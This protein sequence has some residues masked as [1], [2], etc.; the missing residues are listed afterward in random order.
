VS[1]SFLSPR[2]WR[3]EDSHRPA[4]QEPA[5]ITPSAGTRSYVTC[6]LRDAGGDIRYLG[7]ASGA[8]EH[9]VEG[10]LQEALA[11]AGIGEVTG[12]GSGL[13]VSNLDVE[14]TDLDAGLA[15]VR[16]VLRDLEVPPSTMIYLN[17]G[18]ALKGT[19]KVTPYPVYQRT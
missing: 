7:G 1:T 2:P 5:N 13:G 15:L 11:A 8:G 9:E 17:E 19:D 12:A 10:S 18:D 3:P 4:G 14:I 6:G 16:K